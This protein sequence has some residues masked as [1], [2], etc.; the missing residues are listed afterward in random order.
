M[1]YFQLVFQTLIYVCQLF[2]DLFF[3]NYKK[4]EY[5]NSFI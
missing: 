5:I 4:Y 1:K 3:K 2:E